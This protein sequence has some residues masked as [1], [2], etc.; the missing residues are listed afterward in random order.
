MG[1]KCMIYKQLISVKSISIEEPVRMV[2]IAVDAKVADSELLTAG[3]TTLSIAWTEGV[4]KLSYRDT[5]RF[6]S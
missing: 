3:P 6:T 4:S 5:P 2:I 1:M